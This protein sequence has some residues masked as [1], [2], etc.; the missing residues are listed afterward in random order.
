MKKNC[1]Y[2]PSSVVLCL[3]PLSLAT[4]SAQAATFT[5]TN[6]NDSGPGSLRAAMTSANSSASSTIA[7]KIP[8][9]LASGGVFTIKPRTELPAITRNGTIIDGDTQTKST[10]NT[11][12]AGPE[13]VLNGSL[14]G[15]NASGLL[16][17]AANCTVKALV[18]N[19]FQGVRSEH[20]RHWSDR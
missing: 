3:A 13:I 19:A 8:L 10:G 15:T 1:T 5:V 11:N 4:A 17:T 18:I 7:F 2:F 16:I 20:L 9:S 12:A 6:I 14:A